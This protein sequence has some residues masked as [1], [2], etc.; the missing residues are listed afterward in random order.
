MWL[1]LAT[2]HAHLARGNALALRYPSDISPLAGLPA[3]RAANVAALT[4]LVDVGDDVALVGPHQPVLPDDWE[5]L[6]TSNITQMLRADRSP[7]PEGDAEVAKLGPVDVDEML[8]LVEL[9]KPGPFRRRTIELGTYIGIRERGRLVAM[10]GER[11]W[12]GEHREVSAICTHPE[13]QGRGYARALIGRVV[14]RMLRAGETPY[15]HVESVNS[16]AIDVYLALGFVRRT[17][18]PLLYARRMR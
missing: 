7:L 11:T 8:A 2:R 15:L 3:A 10:A 14:N 17:E 16:R 4:K 12:I 5:T 6:Y 13:A 9:T 18:F 1:C